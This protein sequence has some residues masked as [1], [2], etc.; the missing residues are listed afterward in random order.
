MSKEEISQTI[1]K[2]IE[3]WLNELTASEGEA[4]KVEGFSGMSAISIK[5]KS[6][7]SYWIRINKMGEVTLDKSS[8]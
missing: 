8:I 1:L 6:G 4:T 7:N 2:E 3:N 5:F